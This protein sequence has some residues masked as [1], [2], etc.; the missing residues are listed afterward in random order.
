MSEQ[1]AFIR[2][3]Y[4]FAAH[5][6][7][8]AHRQRP[9]DVEDRRMAIYRELFYNNLESL[10]AAN[11]PV[12]RKLLA[13]EHWHGMVRDFF[14]KHRCETP[15][16]LEIG[17]EFL[18][19]LQN[20]HES[21]PRDPPFLIEL[22]HYEW[23]E[24]ALSVSNESADPDG[25]DPNGDLMA[26][27]PVL[28]PLAWNLSYRFPVHRIGPD[29]LPDQPGEEPT[30]LVVYRSRQDEVEFLVINAVTQRLLQLLQENPDWTGHET[31][32]RIAQELK[33]PR[34]AQVMEAGHQLLNDLHARNIVLGTRRQAS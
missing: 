23:V 30:H 7:D 15:L 12:L 11:F 17:Q 32:K 24:L 21:E 18:D 34:P 9:A 22:A 5:I 14:V 6:R 3:Q 29:F 4:E 20:E 2:R 13:D 25:A 33:H 28:S 27:V 8:P 31:V 10:L 1:P 19:Y 16:F 26:D